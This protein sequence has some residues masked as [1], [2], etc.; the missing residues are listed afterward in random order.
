MTPDTRNLIA[1]A[2][3][4]MLV[5][6]GWQLYFVE[7]DLEAQRAEYNAAQMQNEGQNDLP[8][9][10]PASSQSGSSQSGGSQSAGASN[11]VTLGNVGNR[12]S[13]DAKR[14][15]IETP[16]IKGS[17]T[18][19]GARIDDV[20]LTAYQ[21]TLED[22]SPDITLLH[23][24]S[25]SA[26]YFAEF[27]WIGDNSD[28]T[29]P[30]AD[31]IWTASSDELTP[32]RDVTLTYDNGEGLLF[33]RTLSIDEQYMMTITDEVTS[34]LDETLRLLPYGLIRRFGTPQTTGIYILHEGP[35]G[36]VD[37]TLKERSY[38]DLRDET[39]EFTSEEAG[40]WVGF[41]D[42]YWLTALIPAQEQMANFSM[43]AL[44]GNEDRYQT[45]YLGAPLVLAQGETIRYEAHFFAGAKVLDMID[46]YAEELAIPNF[47]LAIDFGWFYFMTKPFFYAINWLYGVFGNFGVAILAFTVLIRIVLYPLADKSYRSMAKMRALSPKL[48]KMREQ[49]KDDRQKLNQ[50]MMAL[51]R[52]EK[53]NP[54]AGC[55]PILL[56]IPVF[57]ALYKVLYVSLEM[58]HAPFFGWIHDLSEIDPT[59]IFN[60]FGLLP[61]STAYI[62]DFLNIGLWPVA[63]GLS[64]FIQQKLNPPP[65]DPIQ[66]KIFQWMP[67]AFTFLLAGFPAGLVIYWTWN[68][69]LSIL[70]QW[71]ITRRIEKA[72]KA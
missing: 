63:M 38:G 5:L 26:P 7:P 66:A 1:A 11:N 17:L 45:D 18:T 8:S 48:T 51:Y 71:I 13:D 15:T 43:R 47:D 14:I 62:P 35:I 19:K 22:G 32:N 57:F 52:Q 30:N 20:T 54:A 72:M 34:A 28:V 65:P 29:L 2:S 23:K 39:S 10:S 37:T 40:G 36:V 53:V 59:S 24:I 21:E 49:H 4:S 41:T 12:P 69:T 60:L 31:T 50:E 70:Q 9:S 46:D 27:G 64:M 67:I 42:K 55:L 68:N 3:L 61:Y 56:Q 58:R 25:D 6:V 44:A 33:T 16:L